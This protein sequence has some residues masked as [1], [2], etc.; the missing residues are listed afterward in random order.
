M[1]VGFFFFRFLPFIFNLFHLALPVQL[2]SEKRYLNQIVKKV[3]ISCLKL[4]MVGKGTSGT[5]RQ[6]T[7]N[8]VA[9]VV[10]SQ[11]C[12][13]SSRHPDS[14]GRGQVQRSYHST[15][16]PTNHVLSPDRSLFL[17]A[18]QLLL[19]PLPSPPDRLRGCGLIDQWEAVSRV[20][21]RQMFGWSLGFFEH[22]LI[23]WSRVNVKT[24]GWRNWNELKPFLS[25]IILG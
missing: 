16:S 17:S 25:G 7:V 21:S 9:P 23:W 14:W 10:Y 19:F 6:L 24:L 4:L 1:E 2:K 5:H 22:Q 3:Q 11:Q 15:L 18:S 12:L 8:S 13:F 20:V